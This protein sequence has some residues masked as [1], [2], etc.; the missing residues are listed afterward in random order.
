MARNR[1]SM[2][3]VMS[4]RATARVVISWMLVGSAARQP[5]H[6]SP[7]FLAP[8]LAQI[9]CAFSVKLRAAVGGFSEGAANLVALEA[10]SARAP[11]SVLSCS[12]LSAE[13]S[14]RLVVAA[15]VAAVLLPEVVIVASQPLVLLLA[16]KVAA[17]ATLGLAGAGLLPCACPARWAIV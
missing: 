10:T 4:A 11:N 16:A 13:Y 5:L 6:E 2:A 15:V 17:A 3:G 14:E 8:Q 12:E 1:S 9:A 7:G